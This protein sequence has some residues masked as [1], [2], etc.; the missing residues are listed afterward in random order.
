MYL[1]SNPLMTQ[2]NI[3]KISL[4]GELSVFCFFQGLDKMILSAQN[5]LRV[6]LGSVKSTCS[7]DY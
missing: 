5:G 3:K 2:I 6:D 1:L 7:S 4:I